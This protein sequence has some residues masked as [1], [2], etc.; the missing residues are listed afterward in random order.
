MNCDIALLQ[1]V[2]LTETSLQTQLAVNAFCRS[3]SPPI[4]ASF[5]FV[6]ATSPK[7]I[8]SLIVVTYLF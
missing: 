2:V 8:Y 7:L 1:C 3:H 4:K 6:Y 5:T